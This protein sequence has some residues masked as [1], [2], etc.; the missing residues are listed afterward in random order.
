M[1]LRVQRYK[2]TSEKYEVYF[3]IFH[4]ECN[5]SYLK[6][7]KSGQYSRFSLMNC[8]FLPQTIYGLHLI[9]RLQGCLIPI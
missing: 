5:I 6:I 4:S 8:I 7:H 1:G 9:I 3:N 2:Q